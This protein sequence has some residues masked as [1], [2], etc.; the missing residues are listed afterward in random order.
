MVPLALTSSAA[1]TCLAT[2]SAS[3][4]S[5]DTREEV[6]GLD[7]G[8]YPA[9]DLFRHGRPECSMFAVV[10]L[11]LVDRPFLVGFLSLIAPFSSDVSGNAFIPPKC[12]VY[13]SG[14]ELRFRGI[15]GI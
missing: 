2:S 12:V 4:F 3:F 7:G 9:L 15:P 10:L 8:L 11:D 5:S 14:T 6:L 13:S 1:P